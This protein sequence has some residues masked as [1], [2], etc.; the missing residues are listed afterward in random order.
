MTKEVVTT[1]RIATMHLIIRLLSTPSLPLKKFVGRL[2]KK[3]SEAYEPNGV[4]EY[5]SNGVLRFKCITPLFHHSN[6][7]VF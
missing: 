1:T 5:G 4:L 3:I 7:P 6:T 2:L